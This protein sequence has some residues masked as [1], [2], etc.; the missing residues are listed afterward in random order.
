MIALIDADLILYRVGF[1]TEDIDSSDIVADRVDTL[2]ND[3]IL[4]PLDTKEYKCFITGPQNY[5]RTIYPEYKK[6]R[7]EKPKPR[8]YQWIKDYLIEYYNAT[9]EDPYEADDIL[10]I[11]QTEDTVIC[12][13]DKD[14][15][16]VPGF[17]FNWVNGI[18]SSISPEQGHLWLCKQLLMGDKT[19]DIPGV[20]LI[21]KS[22][23]SPRLCFGP[24]SVDKVLCKEA[25]DDPLSE[26]IKIYKKVWPE[27]WKK[28]LDLRGSLVH[29]RTNYIT[30]ETP[31][32]SYS[33]EI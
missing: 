19:D 14:L 32:W 2:I 26:V 22:G 13:I 21:T 8:H 28:E 5:R 18:I 3:T 20:P 23:V 4:G 6:S 27:T 7:V 15:L 9:Y 12:S 24:A 17:H 30:E 1:T 29:I 33:G 16:Q 31:I 10:G 11:N 25:L